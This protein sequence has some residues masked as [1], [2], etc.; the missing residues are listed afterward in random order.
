M[1]DKVNELRW[2][3]GKLMEELTDA[4]EYAKSAC[5]HKTKNPEEAKKFDILASDEQKHAGMIEQE[6]SNIVKATTPESPEHIIYDFMSDAIS[7]AWMKAKAMQ[8]R[9]KGA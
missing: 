1:N 8:S 6:I 2:L 9:Y 3:Y 7:D 5:E 4:E